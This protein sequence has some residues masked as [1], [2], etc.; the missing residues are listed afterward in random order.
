MKLRK[1]CIT[2]AQITMAGGLITSSI[3]ASAEL[4]EYHSSDYYKSYQYDEKTDVRVSSNGRYIAYSDYHYLGFLYP[5]HPRRWALRNI[6]LF[7]RQAGTNINLLDGNFEAEC[8]SGSCPKPWDMS[9]DGKF[10]VFESMSSTLVEGDTDNKGDIFLLDIASGNVSM[11]TTGIGITYYGPTISTTGKYITYY[12]RENVSFSTVM[13]TYVFNVE[14]GETTLVDTGEGYFD[15]LSNPDI[16][17]DGKFV[18]SDTAN[19]ATFSLIN[20]EEQSQILLSDSG[21][22]RGFSKLSADG[23]FALFHKTGA[24]RSGP[25]NIYD[26]KTEQTSVLNVIANGSNSPINVA[27]GQFSVSGDGR[28]IAFVSEANGLVEYDVDSEADVFVYDR[29]EHQV[30]RVN[31]GIEYGLRNTSSA[32]V[33]IDISEDGHYIVFN[34]YVTTNP[35]FSSAEYC[36]GYEEF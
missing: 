13:F 34:N 8:Y 14:T 6:N 15:D 19:G 25:L 33:G 30:V 22:G 16:S 21:D 28:F 36:Q 10:L 1:L 12:S 32:T 24:E 5:D 26:T 11:I 18:L 4:E 7:D 9:R 27:Q 17:A 2:I 29:I 20:T 3:S 31:E 23:R 35:F